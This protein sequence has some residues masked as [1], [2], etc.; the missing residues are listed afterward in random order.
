MNIILTGFASCGKSTTANAI[1]AQASMR[2]TDLDRVIEERYER[3]Y[4]KRAS[5]REIFTDAGKESFAQL[6]NDALRSLSNL[7]NSV[8]ST[9]GRTPMHKENRAILKSLGTVVYLKA[10]AESVLARMKRKGI[11]KSIG[12]TPEEVRAE[13][14]R[15][16]PVYAEF[17]DIV[18]ENDNLTPAETAKAILEKMPAPA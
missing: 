10:G 4:G 13:W 11:P 2:H 12:T 7:R 18:I 16:E 3:K 17:A 5:V 6:E 9:G 15:R 1:C 8:L 14:E